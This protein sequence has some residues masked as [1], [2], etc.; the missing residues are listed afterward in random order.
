MPIRGEW[1]PSLLN[2][3]HTRYTGT[4]SQLP[5][6]CQGTPFKIDWVSKPRQTNQTWFQSRTKGRESV[7]LWK[8]IRYEALSSLILLH[9]DVLSTV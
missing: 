1:L 3:E 9:V 2:L 6:M 4:D 7:I 8:V 5:C